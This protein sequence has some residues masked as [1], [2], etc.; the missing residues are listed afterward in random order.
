MK[1][2]PLNGFFMCLTDSLNHLRTAGWKSNLD[3]EYSYAHGLIGG[4]MLVGA[5][6]IDE[7]DRLM[8]LMKNAKDYA[9]KEMK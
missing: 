6:T 9:M 3:R 7:R 8:T 2:N 4:A 1:Y 5:I